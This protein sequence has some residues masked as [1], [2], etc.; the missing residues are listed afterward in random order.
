MSTPRAEAQEWHHIV[1]AS[2]RECLEAR[3]L[4]R[5]MRFF[6]HP[7]RQGLHAAIAIAYTYDWR[8]SEILSLG[9]AS[10]T[11]RP[12]RCASTPGPQG[13]GKA[14]PC[15]SLRSSKGCWRAR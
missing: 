2:V 11:S 15:T 1:R 8:K 7:M 4:S 10:L 6:L 12:G 9:G 14:V 3:T 5:P 13:I